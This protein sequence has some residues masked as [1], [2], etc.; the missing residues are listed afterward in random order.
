MQN[1]QRALQ[2]GEYLSCLDLRIDAFLHTYMN[3]FDYANYDLG[4]V[5]DSSKLR[6]GVLGLQNLPMEGSQD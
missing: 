5:S 4:A 6:C 1:K 3:V 2:A